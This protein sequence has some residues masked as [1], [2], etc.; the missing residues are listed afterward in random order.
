MRKFGSLLELQSCVGEEIG[1]SDWIVV[2]QKRIDT[3]ADATGDRQWIHVDPQRAA[4]GPFG[5]TV[6]HGYLTLSLIPFLMS[7]AIQV[8]GVKMGVNYGLNKVRFPSP[9][10]VGARVRGR[11]RLLGM[12]PLPLGGT[13]SGFQLSMEVTIECEGS[14]K[15]ACVAETLSRR[16]C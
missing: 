13:L 15:P 7:S 16:Y 9:V 2:D 3:F 14:S 8:E 6:A 4:T 12:E 11:C 1:V 5:V 10:K